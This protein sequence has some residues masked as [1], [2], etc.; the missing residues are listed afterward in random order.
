MDAF[1]DVVAYL[2]ASLRNAHV[3]IIHNHY[4]GQSISGCPAAAAAA[5]ANRRNWIEIKRNLQIDS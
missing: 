2:P 1:L 3:L 5:P 4:Y